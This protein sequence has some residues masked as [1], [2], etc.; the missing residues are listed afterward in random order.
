MN[1]V[2]KTEEGK[3]YVGWYVV[4]SFILACT[5]VGAIWNEVV[6]KRPWKDY[7]NRFHKLEFEDAK[8]RYEEAVL[9]FEQPGV[10]RSY[11]TI[12]KKLS[13]ARKDFES[14]KIQDE[15][16]KTLEALHALDK[17]ELSPLRF[18]AIVL[19]NKMS[20]EKYLFGKYKKEGSTEKINVMEKKNKELA[21]KI[22]RLD[23]KRAK[24]QKKLD[25][26]TS[27]V[28][29]YTK[30]MESHE[31][32]IHKYKKVMEGLSSKRPQLQVYQVRFDELNEVDRCMSCHVGINKKRNVS[33]EQPY[34]A[35]PRRDVYLGNHPPEKFGCVLCHEGQARATTSAEKAHG[36]VEY[37]LKP[38][39]RGKVAQSSCIKCHDKAERLEGGEEIWKGVKLFEEL[40]CYG[41]HPTEGFGEDE[42]SMIGPDL[43]EISSKVNARWMVGWLQGPRDF[44]PT[45]RMPDFMLDEDEARA[46]TSYLWQNSSVTEVKEQNGFSEEMIEEGANLFESIGCLAC[47]S[48]IADDEERTHGPNLARIGEKISYKYLV[49]WLLGPKSHQPLTRMPDFRLDEE[50]SRFLAAYLMS[51]KSEDYEEIEEDAGWV[52][53]EMMGKKGGELISRYGCFG[54]HKIRGMEGRSRI[55][56]ELTEIGSKNLHLFD[57]GLFEKE[58]LNGVGLQNA[59]ENIGKARR[60]W[61]D[62]KLSNPR[63]FDEGR[64]KRPEDRL[65][66]PDFGLSKE[67]RGSLLVLLSGL[68]EGEYPERY[69]DKL[70]E[71][72]KYLAEG[73]RVIDKY[74]C[75]GCHQ[76]T[77]DKLYL[78][79]GTE[80]LGMVK[81]EEENNLF[82]Q[83]WEDN[84]GLGR[85]AGE[86]AQIMKSQ[87]KSREKAEGGDISSFIID[88][89]VE[90]EGRVP[91]EAKVFT[92]PVLYGEGKKVQSAWLFRFLSKPVNLRP[93][94]EVRM[95][96]FNF[97]GKDVTSLTR[98]FAMKD[99][100]EYPY[101]FY[102]ET[103]EGYIDEKEREMPGYL[104][105]AK[106]L[107]ESRDVNCVSCHVRG[108]ITPEG[109]PSDWAPDLS[110]ASERLKPDWIVRWLL[111]PQI[112]QPG[113]KMPKFFRKDVFQ[114]LFSGTP[115]EQAEAIKDLLMNFPRDMLRPEGPGKSVKN[116]LK[117][118]A[119]KIKSS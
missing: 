25:G 47:H 12:E 37:W 31:S 70:T 81:L 20:E 46:I 118:S 97:Q 5:G 23:E 99:E 105:K 73:K 53:D 44:R 1:K 65:R 21:E 26:L 66:M 64:Y 96:T 85:K 32:S 48:D 106:N 77:I 55:G 98:Y 24:L 111:N 58:I 57:F 91:E 90:E 40:D 80:V 79:G 7:Q 60:A 4:L 34:A 22:E 114:D 95:P 39:Y 41:C 45:T 6:S 92:P 67:E 62:A 101:E 43:M 115:T 87:I 29:R 19:R 42:Y 15:Y 89:H 50:D 113:T 112:I 63:R 11:K 116:T 86:T 52:N 94:L 102:K 110:L 109:G 82:F 72:Q 33:E 61:I 10:P 51:L 17:G 9:A 104:A 83:L 27:E 68:K 84:E 76:F 28:V 108:D 69:V 59:E 117:S 14:P 88:Y 71:T 2:K 54:C 38:M 3:S 78:E 8:K 30:D 75:M 35:H 119:G 18:E 100:Q 49:S 36:E 93:W 56:V 16:K 103:D 13:E 107:F 74:N